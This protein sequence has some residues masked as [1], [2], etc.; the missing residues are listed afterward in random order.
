[1][2]ALLQLW[3]TRLDAFL[4]FHHGNNPETETSLELDLLIPVSQL[5]GFEY[6]PSV[7]RYHEK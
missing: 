1:M 5:Y 6:Y 7:H 3:K 2:T 4:A